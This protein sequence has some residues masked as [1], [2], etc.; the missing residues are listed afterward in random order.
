M[1]MLS[2]AELAME[3]NVAGHDAGSLFHLYD[4]TL[5]HLLRLAT[6][7]SLLS[8]MRT[9][10]ALFALGLPAL[11]GRRHYLR[12]Q[13]LQSFYNFL[14]TTSPSSFLALRD[15]DF[16]ADSWGWPGVPQV[17]GHSAIILDILKRAVNLQAL[18]FDA[19]LL[20]LDGGIDD[21]IMSLSSL[22][23]LEITGDFDFDLSP[24]LLSRLH[25]PLK[26]IELS[27]DDGIDPIP[28][29]TNFSHSLQ[30]VVFTCVSFP[31]VGNVS[32]P[33]VTHLKAQACF[34][35][36]APAL[37]AAFPNVKHIHL[38]CSSI[39]GTPTDQSANLDAL[40]PQ[41]VEFQK[42][43]RWESLLSAT[44]DLA[45][46]YI[47]ALQCEVPSI[48]IAE[49]LP[50][51]SEVDV[52]W[53]ASSLRLLRPHY[54]KLHVR[55]DFTRLLEI[56]SAGMEKVKRLDICI[57]LASGLLLEE[58]LD[59]F[60]EAIRRFP[61]LEHV[62][63]E[64]VC[65]DTMLTQQ[66]METLARCVAEASSTILAISI[67]VSTSTSWGVV[68]RLCWDVTRKSDS[69]GISEVENHDVLALIR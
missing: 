55:S 7:K 39:V 64:F 68:R 45:G 30:T 23:T 38:E 1:I 32:F 41:C 8:L 2:S 61:V 50:T 48:V 29:L 10:R 31:S 17:P 4:D 53:L 66:N 18:C 58:S 21:A 47:L 3:N 59:A 11:L 28:M 43:Q 34:H 65:A 14:Q 24:D 13:S 6:D 9:C 36:C 62:D 16:S 63:I 33:E 35:P 46:L 67:G 27:L 20:S 15:L 44:V 22:R 69:S 57:I 40:L 5:L 54:L 25:V 19:A 49:E 37:I 26:H 42:H 51:A 12:S 56:L 60:F 52:T